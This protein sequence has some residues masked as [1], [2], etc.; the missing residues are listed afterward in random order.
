MPGSLLVS[1]AGLAGEQAALVV[2]G[3]G[4]CVGPD[5][6]PGAVPLAGPKCRRDGWAA[7]EGEPVAVVLDQ[8]QAVDGLDLVW[9][10]L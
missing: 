5:Q 6:V 4:R 2:E 9:P 7:R 8:E 3:V 10:G 1:V